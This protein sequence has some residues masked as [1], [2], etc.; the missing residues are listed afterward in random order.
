MTEWFS[1][2]HLR[3]RIGVNTMII[4]IYISVKFINSVHGVEYT[5]VYNKHSKPHYSMTRKS[6]ARN[7]DVCMVNDSNDAPASCS[8]CQPRERIT[9]AHFGGSQ[10]RAPQSMIAS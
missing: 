10:K 5:V 8:I 3:T 2:M 1:S 6:G 9:V 7:F 4:N